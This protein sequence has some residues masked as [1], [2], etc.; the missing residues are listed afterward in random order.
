MERCTSGGK[1][2]IIEDEKK[3][4]I[5]ETGDEARQFSEK[6]KSYLLKAADDQVRNN[7][8]RNKLQLVWYLVIAKISIYYVE[9]GIQAISNPL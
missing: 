4:A 8:V 3:R 5:I 2:V 9:G 1:K 7:R 6:W